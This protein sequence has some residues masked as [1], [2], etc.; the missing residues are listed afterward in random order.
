MGYVIVGALVLSGIIQLSIGIYVIVQSNRGR[1]LWFSCF[2]IAASVYSFGYAFELTAQTVR[3]ALVYMRIEYLGIAFLPTFGLLT[4]LEFTGKRWS[5]GSKPAIAMLAFSALTVV[6]MHT[7]DLHHLYYADLL[8][9]RVGALTIIQITRGPWYTV[10]MTYANLVLVLGAIVVARSIVTAPADLKAGHWLFLAGF[11]LIGLSS[12]ANAAGLSPCGVDLTPYGFMAM[13]VLLLI[14]LRPG[15]VFDLV[16]I[17]KSRVFD[18]MDDI[19][20]IIDRSNRV[21]DYNPALHQVVPDRHR[22]YVGELLPLVFEKSPEIAEFAMANRD[23]ET[24]IA[25]DDGSGRVFK[26]RLRTVGQNSR[27]KGRQMLAKYL[28]MTDITKEMTMVRTMKDLADL[29]ALTG[30]A[31]RRSFYD[32]IEQFIGRQR[33]GCPVSVI[34]LDIDRF[35]AVNDTYGHRAGDIVLQRIASLLSQNT[36]AQ[37]ILA[38]YGG[39]EFI[40]AIPDMG[41]GSAVALAERLRMSI[42]D[43]EEIYDG[44]SI[45]VTASFGV[46]CNTTG[47][48]FSMESLIKKADTAL[49]KAKSL[50]RDTV[51]VIH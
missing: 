35:K 22:D 51:S 20:V 25:L 9:T 5:R 36:R 1:N 16:S 8:L 31:N 42:Y 50:G 49:Y 39:E 15:Q 3:Q 45:K 13:N 23:S 30:I 19:V 48:G 14:G 37:D 33:A 24:T 34:M 28:T 12:N 29:D 6:G 4:A 38:R 17:A 47:P 41:A 32:Q 26:A 27:R 21:A 7:T 18:G 2:A 46:A 11:A 44:Q 43:F 40:L 10:A